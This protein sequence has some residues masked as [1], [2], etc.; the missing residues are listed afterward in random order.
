MLTNVLFLSVLAG[1]NSSKKRSKKQ[2]L[3]E[4]NQKDKNGSDMDAFATSEVSFLT[5]SVPYPSGLVP[6]GH[7]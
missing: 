2:K 1:N 5:F 3:R 7:M 4:L 6:M